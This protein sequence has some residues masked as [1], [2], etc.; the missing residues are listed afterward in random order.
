[1]LR[2]GAPSLRRAALARPLAPWVSGIRFS[3][4]SAPEPEENIV[5]IRYSYFVPRVGVNA[6]NLPVYTDLRHQGNKWLT[7]I[8]KIDGDVH[9]LC[10]DLFESFG[11]GDP[12]NKKNK[13]ASMVE[14]VTNTNGTRMIVLRGNFVREV[15]EWLEQ[16]GF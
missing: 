13:Y 3:S 10:S 14:R 4:S 11:W 1:M 6:N 15:N 7:V 12:F 8:R 2:V 9:L 5:P 16:R